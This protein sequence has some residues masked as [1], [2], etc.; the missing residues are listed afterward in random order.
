MDTVKKEN[1]NPQGTHKKN[2]LPEQAPVSKTPEQK[3]AT[4]E[5]YLIQ[6]HRAGF[7]LFPFKK[8]ETEE[9]RSFPAYKNESDFIKMNENQLLEFHLKNK[10]H[11]WLAKHPGYKVI[12]T[13]SKED[14]DWFRANVFH[15]LNNSIFFQVK[16]QRGC[17]YYISATFKLNE[18]EQKIKGR[19]IDILNM[20][21]GVFIPY[22]I[23]E[24]TGKIGWLPIKG[25]L[26]YIVNNYKPPKVLNG[27][28]KNTFNKGSYQRTKEGLSNSPPELQTS[29]DVINKPVKHPQEPQMS[30][31]VIKQQTAK[32]PL[33]A[34]IETTSKEPDI[35][36]TTPERKELLKIINKKQSPK[37]LVSKENLP[38][39]SDQ[40]KQAD[41]LRDLSIRIENL[42]APKYYNDAID[43]I[44]R[45]LEKEDPDLQRRFH[46]WIGRGCGAE[47]AKENAVLQ[48]IQR[49]DPY[50]INPDNEINPKNFVFLNP[51][52]FGNLFIRGFVIPLSAETGTGKTN[53]SCYIAREHLKKFPKA[54]LLIL[55][56][57]NDWNHN[58]VSA[59]HI[60]GGLSFDEINKRVEYVKI[61]DY[62]KQKKE[63]FEKIK[64]LEPNDFLILDPARF[65]ANKPNDN[66]EVDNAIQEY[67]SIVRERDIYCL[68]LHHTSMDWRGKSV[69]QQ[70]KF[71]EE[72]VSTPQHDLILKEKAEGE[73]ILFI[74]K[75]NFVR[76]VGAF[77]FKIKSGSFKFEKRDITNKPYIE[78]GYFEEIS[79]IKIMKKYFKNEQG[80]ETARKLADST[81]E[82]RGIIVNHLRNLKG[83]VNEYEKRANLLKKCTDK[84]FNETKFKNTIT[85]LLK[86]KTIY[87]EAGAYNTSSYK[88][89]NDPKD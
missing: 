68:F 9:C 45:E 67:E 23:R 22:S 62:R 17:H 32:P 46:I 3:E 31:E 27:T 10:P 39:Q 75:S 6:Y 60:N 81:E 77:H 71:C 30:Q 4:L 40:S 88:L 35:K 24:D 12:K 5:W 11:G 34:V 51:D 80:V 56:K 43:F 50:P 49:N 72:W 53:I 79:T 63:I 54:R 74:Q 15:L 66:V 21:T 65:I 33:P 26:K 20:K 69:K 19:K 55:D 52:K 85:S 64:A 1:E 25:K 86:E 16:T 29:Q 36:K 7:Y 84:G 14:D 8:I 13:D 38:H 73:C 37:E 61:K 82:I 2:C 41:N 76:R 18:I 59:L 42:K 70:S 78:E 89:L 44:S 87:V 58:I 83:G 47:Q 57:E 48:Y 28:K